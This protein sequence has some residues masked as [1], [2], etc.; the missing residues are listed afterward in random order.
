MDYTDP[1]DRRLRDEPTLP[2]SPEEA[3]I[4]ASLYSANTVAAFQTWL[5][6]GC[7]PGTFAP[8]PSTSTHTTETNEKETDPRNN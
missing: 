6:G 5:L 1:A 2:L 8:F 3:Q 7:K 4:A